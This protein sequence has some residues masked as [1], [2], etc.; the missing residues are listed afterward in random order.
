VYVAAELCDFSI[1]GRLRTGVDE[2]VSLEIIRIHDT[3]H[4]HQPRFDSAPIHTADD[5]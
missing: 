4:V 1:I 2:K 3:Q 5:M